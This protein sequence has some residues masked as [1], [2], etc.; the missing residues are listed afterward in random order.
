VSGDSKPD[1]A[2]LFDDFNTGFNMGLEK[3]AVSHYFEK[4][5]EYIITRE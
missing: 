1:G 5:A 2:P 3:L 4:I